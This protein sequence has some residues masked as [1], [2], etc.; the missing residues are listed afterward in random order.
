MLLP[1]ESEE[2]LTAFPAIQ[3]GMAYGSGAIQQGGYT[4]YSYQRIAKGG[5]ASRLNRMADRIGAGSED[6]PMIDFIFVVEDSVSWHKENLE[7]N[8]SHYTSSIPFLTGKI[9]GMVQDN[10][11]AYLWFNAYVPL[12][13]TNRLMKYGV[14]NRKNILTDLEHWNTLYIAGRMHKPVH[15]IKSDPE[16]EAAMENNRRHAVRTSLMLLPQKFSE[17]DL[18]LTIASLSY[19]GKQ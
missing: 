6:L 1:E 14:I 19:I 9:I 11:P 12:K 8:P 15:I 16:I 3:F 18:F 10:I 4:K 13:S 7:R 2:I 5:D 17:R